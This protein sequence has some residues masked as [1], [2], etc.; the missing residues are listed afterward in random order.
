MN[1]ESPKVNVTKSPQEVFN[2]LED[3]KNFKSLMPENI[4]KFEVLDD[5][6]FLFALK[7]MPEIVLKKKEVIPPNKIVLGAAGGKL[8]FSLIGN[9]VE[10]ADGN[11]E[12][13]LEFAGD[14]NPM[15]AMMI[16]GPIT[17]FIET[18]ATNMPKAI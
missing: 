4:S 12:V 5:D 3:I 1:L 11:S 2:F 9:I 13:Q 15:M 6:K 18:L 14:F 17:K 7:G 10:T 8:D 16:K